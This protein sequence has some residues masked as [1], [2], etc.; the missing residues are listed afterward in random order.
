[1]TIPILTSRFNNDTWDENCKY[2]EKNVTI[3]CVYGSPQRIAEKV[4]LNSIVFVIEM[5][6]QTNKIMGIG[7]IRNSISIDKYYRVYNTGNY[8]RYVYM[9]KYHLDVDT[10]QA[11]NAELVAVFENI[12]FKGKTHLKRGSGSTSIPE[13]LFKQKICQDFVTHKQITDEIIM[14]FKRY[15][16]MDIDNIDAKSGDKMKEKEELNIEN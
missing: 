6:N 11:Y 14:M 8:N 5:N 9:S 3:S 7:L 13:K 12:L 15:Y 1:M 4:P 10:I 2:R 16:S